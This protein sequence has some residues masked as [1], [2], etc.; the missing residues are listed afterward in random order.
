M[1]R[2]RVKTT[3]PNG[4]VCWTTGHD[5]RHAN[6]GRRRE[7]KD[8]KHSERKCYYEK[9]RRRLREEEEGV[10]RL[11]L[12]GGRITGCS[13]SLFDYCMTVCMTVCVSV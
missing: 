4:R 3:R 5:G 13:D 1:Q 9:E 6:T 10:E 12:P 7:G 11:Q 8:V 2:E